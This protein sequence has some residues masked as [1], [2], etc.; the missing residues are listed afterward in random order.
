MPNLIS[1]ALA[2]EVITILSRLNRGYWE[3][4]YWEFQ[5]DADTIFIEVSIN[6]QQNNIDNVR[7]ISNI[8]RAVLAPLIPSKSHELSWC[9]SINCGGESLG[10]GIGGMDDDWKTLGIDTTNSRT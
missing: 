9:G 8:L 2:Q 1:D 10:G 5:D 6:K 7:A 3:S 4:L